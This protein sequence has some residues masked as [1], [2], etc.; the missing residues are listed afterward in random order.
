MTIISQLNKSALKPPCH[1][2]EKAFDSWAK[3]G[4]RLLLGSADLSTTV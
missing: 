2:Y 4:A 3:R 1:H